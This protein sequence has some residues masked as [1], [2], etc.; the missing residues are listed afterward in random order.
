[1]TNTIGDPE[2]ITV[3]KD[4]AFDAKQRAF[5]YARVIEIPTPRWTTYDA[6]F[7]GVDRP[8]MVEPTACRVATQTQQLAQRAQGHARRPCRVQTLSVGNRLSRP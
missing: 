7:F 8:A 1:M 4:P 6:A 2:L 3:W 5:Y